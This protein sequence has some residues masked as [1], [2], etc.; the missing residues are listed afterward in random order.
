MDFEITKDNFTMEQINALSDKTV[1]SILD[2]VAQSA[3]AHW[4]KIA[5]EDKSHLKVDYLQ[6]IQP[7]DVGKNTW[8]ISLVGEIAHLIENGA[9]RLD[10]RTTLLG[11]NVPV[12][13]MGKKGKR[14][15]KDGGFYRAIPFR[16]KNMSKGLPYAG[17]Q[18]TLNRG[19]LNQKVLARAKAIG[20][21]VHREAKNLTSTTTQAYG[22][23]AKKGTRLAAGLAP[24]L[25]A[26]HKTDIYAGMIK[27]SK[28]YEKATQNTYMTFRTISTNVTE[29]WI[30]KPLPA[31]HYAEDVNT[32][33]SKM[34]PKALDAYVK[35]ALK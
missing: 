34:I 25:K 5:K 12:A 1:A 7:I 8:T 31:R 30:R 22:G 2:N 11:P 28:T 29:G 26:H 23:R 20:R 24:K 27:Q 35:E 18:G 10:M 16:H 33:V 6:A 15:N 3:R 21:N 14:E 9:P 17:R 4:I 32:F 13:P 19:S